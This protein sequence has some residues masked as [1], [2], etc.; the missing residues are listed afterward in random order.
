MYD[1]GL[2]PVLH[3]TNM[4]ALKCEFVDH[5]VSIISYGGYS[6]LQTILQKI[7]PWIPV[8][9]GNV[10]VALDALWP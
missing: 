4:T 8:D 7:N 10:V 5:L 1:L 2:H 3:E 6:T 9:K